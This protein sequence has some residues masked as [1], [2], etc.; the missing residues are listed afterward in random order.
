MK[1]TRRVVAIATAATAVTGI[2][3]A[4]FAVGRSLTA[5]DV[6]EAVTFDSTFAGFATGAQEVGG[7][8]VD[9]SASFNVRIDPATDQVCVDVT[10]TGITEDL[11]GM[12]I[13]KGRPGANGGIVVDFGIVAG[14][15][16]DP[17]TNLCVVSTGAITDEIIA[18][19]I[20]FYLNAHTTTFTG[21]AVRGQLEPGGTETFILPTPMRAYDSRQPTNTLGVPAIAANT[22][23][24][25]DLSSYVPPTAIAALVTVTVTETSGA[26]FLTVY[27]ADLTAVPATS[28]VNWTEAGSDVAT[29]TTVKL[30]GAGDIKFTTGPNGGADV[31]IDVLGYLG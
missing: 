27:S 14:T 4:A 30:S 26:G 22:T 17:I 21:G 13:H 8:D 12:H 15:D 5:G 3:G 10:F 2:G 25:V 9:G 20:G 29:T 23:T 24:T 28:T 7:G 6:P 11:V 19:P 16:P 18:D 31:I 1:T